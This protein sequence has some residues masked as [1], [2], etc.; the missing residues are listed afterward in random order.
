MNR[1]ITLSA[2][3]LPLLVF[4]LWLAQPLGGI[5]APG[6]SKGRAVCVLKVTG[7]T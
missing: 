6:Q 1:R 5:A 4:S 3:W 7:M 2:L